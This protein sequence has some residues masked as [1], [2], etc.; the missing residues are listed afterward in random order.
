M[1]LACQP[2]PERRCSRI[3]CASMITPDDTTDPLGI[4]DEALSRATETL[5]M[6][7]QHLDPSLVDV[8][9]ILGYDYDYT[10]ARGS[11][12]YDVN[13]REFLDF[14]SGEGFATLGHNHPDIRATLKATL[15]AELL[16]GVQIQYSP[17]AGMLA[18]A[19]IARLP[20]S[21]DSVF[22]GSTGAEMVD[23]AM[24]FARAAT[25]RRE[26]V[27]TD[28]GYHGVT[29]GPL[30]IVG[31]DF[32]AKGFGPL[33]PGCRRVPH[34]DLDALEKV[35]KRR[36]AA[37]FIVEPIQGVGVNP[38][39]PGYLE[40]AQALCRRY[41]T[42]FVLD[43]VQT[44]LGRTGRWFALEHWNLEP[45][46][47]TVAKALSGGFMP[48]GAMITRREIFQKAV[49]TLER[50]YVQ[51]STYGRN[52]LSMA[53][54]L[55]AMRV[56]ERD[57]LIDHAADMGRR[58]QAGLESL[59]DRYEM[60]SE[61]RGMGL[62]WGIEL[63]A[64]A[65]RVAKLNWHL[66]HL[67]SEGL[68]PQL[69]VIPLHRDHG[70]IT[71][72]SGKNDVVKLLP[73]LT[74][75]AGEIDRFL[76]ALDAVLADLHGSSSRNWG[77]VREIATTTLRRH[78][79]RRDP[80]AAGLE[81]LRGRPVDTTRGDVHLVTGASGFIGGHVAERLLAEGHQVRCLVRSGSD[82][83]RLERLGV[84]LAP[85]S[86]ENPRS[87]QRA[88]E[89]CAYV[90]HCG[91]M[92]S[93]WGTVEEIERVN[94]AGTR[95]LLAAAGEAAVTRFVHVSSTDIYGYPGRAAIEE[96]EPPGG[97]RNWYA[98]TKLSAEAE[99]RQAAGAGLDTV[100]LRPATVWGPHSRETVGEIGGAIK[101]GYMLLVDGGRRI[102][103]LVYIDNLVD[104]MVLALR[105]QQARGEAFN[106]TDGLPVTWRQF[107]DGLADGIGAPGAR[108]SMP[109]GLASG[110]GVCLEEGY[111]FLR[112]TTRLSAPALLSRQAV[113][114][115]GTDQ[116]FSNRKAREVLGW[117]PRV[118]YA[119]GMEATVAWLR[120]EYLVGGR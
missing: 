69:V 92:V 80:A 50:C 115:M 44:G 85:G 111:R 95:H 77:V 76:E 16:D 56:I 30:S 41:G 98:Q 34:G 105:H 108:L 102:A 52:R 89:G 119:Q 47:V 39:P 13:G 58:L 61:V 87:L 27:S 29:Y 53:A 63:A 74:V 64:P 100:V 107:T 10:T 117:E 97:F 11:F 110:V 84:E 49:G 24:K 67:A 96:T 48:T 23:S 71:M 2:R 88:A 6:A 91:A 36:R 93:D 101:G 79:S 12:I 45:D 8:L 7:S 116:D 103:G 32:F 33:L 70:V 14:H 22:F 113:H 25:G 73:P 81:P 20:R 5:S 15:D 65:T 37:A 17:L 66:I 60:V 19:L 28:G 112:R 72:A 86:L 106:V 51:Q 99:V 82:T 31:E 42:L 46:I 21:L 114:I 38:P 118:S 68:F 104:A 3:V 109:Y 120:D 26:I 18:E 57:G 9:T 35:L 62:M 90:V 4:V 94:V 59:R 43:E 78:I 40:G 1:D 55:A 83:R 75:S 54:G